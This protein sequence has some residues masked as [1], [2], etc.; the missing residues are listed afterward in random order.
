MRMIDTITDHPIRLLLHGFTRPVNRRMSA[1][2]SY[3]DSPLSKLLLKG[4]E[5]QM[6]LQYHKWEIAGRPGFC[7]WLPRENL[8]SLGYDF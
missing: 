8:F 1:I 2:C 4:Q 3:E 6:L 5:N 7:L